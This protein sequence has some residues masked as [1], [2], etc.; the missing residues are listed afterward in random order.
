MTL[1][2]YWNGTAWEP[3]AGAGG[4]PTSKAYPPRPQP[5]SVLSQGTVAIGDVNSSTPGM[6]FCP[7]YWIN[8]GAFFEC[9]HMLI[10]D[11]VLN[12]GF[13][14]GDVVGFG[15]VQHSTGASLTTSQST[16]CHAGY[17]LPHFM[18][19]SYEAQPGGA[20]V[21]FGVFWH[22]QGGGSPN[23]HTSGGANWIVVAT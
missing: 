2:R 17:W 22:W 4:T 5:G 11:V 1:A 14:V 3:L 20:N 7:P 18:T 19:A 15:Q 13:G 12:V 10:V 9:R 6:V 23:S 21:Q 16:H 8:P